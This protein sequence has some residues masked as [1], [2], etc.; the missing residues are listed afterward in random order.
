MTPKLPPRQRS[1]ESTKTNNQSK[2]YATTT[3]TTP[4]ISNTFE[5]NDKFTCI[6]QLL[7]L[8][9]VT[10]NYFYEFDHHQTITQKKKKNFFLTTHN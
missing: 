8:L 5:F 2:I 7:I 1:S 6:H 3:A 9:Q 10:R 4:N